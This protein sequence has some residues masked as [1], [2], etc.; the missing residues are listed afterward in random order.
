MFFLSYKWLHRRVAQLHF[1]HSLS[2]ICFL[3]LV[4]C[5]LPLPPFLSLSF[6]FTFSFTK[7]CPYSWSFLSFCLSFSLFALFS[8]LSLTLCPFRSYGLDVVTHFLLTF[9]FL[10][11]SIHSFLSLLIFFVSFLSVNSVYH[12]FLLFLTVVIICHSFISF[13]RFFFHSYPSVFTV[14]Y[15]FYFFLSLISFRL[16]QFTNFSSSVP[17]F[18]SPYCYFHITSNSINL[19][20]SSFYLLPLTF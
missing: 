14:S 11:I 10:Q 6:F 7:F 17:F 2:F 4:S 3:S 12:S 18:I 15:F 20:D 1:G 9:L 19:S 16:L 5:S 8:I 13:L